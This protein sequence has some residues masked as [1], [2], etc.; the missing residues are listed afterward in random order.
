MKIPNMQKCNLSMIYYTK[1][2]YVRTIHYFTFSS[3]Q[4]K[5]IDNELTLHN[6]SFIFHKSENF[7]ANFIIRSFV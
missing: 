3:E 2:F 4:L 5:M 6:M 7:L 1:L